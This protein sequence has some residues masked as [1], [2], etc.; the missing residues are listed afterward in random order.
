M[1]VILGQA[2]IP[3]GLE[4]TLEERTGNLKAFDATKLAT[5]CGS[6]KAVNIVLLGAASRNLP[7]SNEAWMKVI[8]GNV[9]EKFVEMNKFAFTK[10]QQA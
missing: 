9:K 5:E 1:P 2:Q 4:Q 6:S 3:A 8:E 10:G 7:F